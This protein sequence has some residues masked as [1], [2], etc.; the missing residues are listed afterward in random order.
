PL[1]SSDLASAGDDLEL[2]DLTADLPGNP[3]LRNTIPT[4]EASS[5]HLALVP[6]E[7]EAVEDVVPTA[8][9]KQRIAAALERCLAPPLGWSAAH[10]LV[11]A[12][13]LVASAIV[14]ARILRWD[15]A[16][17]TR[18]ADHETGASAEPVMGRQEALGKVALPMSG[19]GD[20]RWPTPA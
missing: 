11:A 17:K 6:G 20:L 12:V 5:P 3:E 19:A 2:I 18:L 1:E 7:V 15:V 9:A 10:F 16:S 8:P 14:S 13:V 4:S